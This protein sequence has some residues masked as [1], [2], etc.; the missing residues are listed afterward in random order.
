MLELR[1]KVY[2]D[3]LDWIKEEDN[4]Y[5]KQDA[6]YIVV[7]DEFNK[8]AGSLRIL[9][10][11]SPWMIEK[12]FKVLLDGY[13]INKTPS[14]IEI[15][16]LFISTEERHLLGSMQASVR[17]FQ[18]LY[19]WMTAGKFDTIYMVVRPEYMRFFRMESF[20][21]V[22]IGKRVKGFDGVAGKIDLNFTMPYMKEKNYELWEWITMNG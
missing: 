1:K 4:F 9:K 19:Q 13:P 11:H 22:P 16:R 2:I 3:E 10:P 15:T 5:D 12:E 8:Q 17:L 14:S 6:V 18:A 20:C 7:Y 21:P